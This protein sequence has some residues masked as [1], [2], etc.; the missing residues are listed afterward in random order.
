MLRRCCSFDRRI[1]HIAIRTVTGNNASTSIDRPS[2]PMSVV[3]GEDNNT[4]SLLSIPTDGI[5]QCLQYMHESMHIPWWLDIATIAIIARTIAFP[6]FTIAE[7]LSAKRFAIERCIID[8]HIAKNV[9]DELFF[10]YFIAI[11]SCFL[12]INMY[13][14]C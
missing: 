12:A 1:F 8:R 3:T 11:I 9:S 10:N 5:Q 6:L 4:L 14:A 7:R 2:L 13:I